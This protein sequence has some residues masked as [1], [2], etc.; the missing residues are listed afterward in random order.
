MNKINIEQVETY[1]DH[2]NIIMNNR[3]SKA[4]DKAGYQHVKIEFQGEPCI[5]FVNNPAGAQFVREWI[6][7][8]D[9]DYGIN[10]MFSQK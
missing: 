6:N 9:Y 2:N 5:K 1:N 4:L 10:L 7:N 3:V 8:S